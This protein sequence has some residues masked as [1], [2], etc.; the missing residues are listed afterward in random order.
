MHQADTFNQ[1]TLAKL[2][3]LKSHLQKLLYLLKSHLQKLRK[4]WKSSTHTHLI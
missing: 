1:S 3:L 4:K 2:Y